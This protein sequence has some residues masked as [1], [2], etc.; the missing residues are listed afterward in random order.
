MLEAGQHGHIPFH[1]ELLKGKLWRNQNEKSKFVFRPEKAIR[2]TKGVSSLTSHYC[3][4]TA[5]QNENH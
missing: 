3:S 1:L 2:G 5:A 4:N